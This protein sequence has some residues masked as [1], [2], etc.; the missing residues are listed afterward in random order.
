[1]V[2]SAASSNDVCWGSCVKWADANRFSKLLRKGWVSARGR[3]WALMTLAERRMLSR[4]QLTTDNS[5]YQLCSVTVR[6][7]L[8]VFI[9][10]NT[11]VNHL[12]IYYL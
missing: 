11:I 12:I 7:A 9:I 10:L 8:S 5:V 4:H 1:M 3:S 6:R 2:A